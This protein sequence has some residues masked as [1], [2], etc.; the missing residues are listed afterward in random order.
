MPS[1]CKAICLGLC[2]VFA[3]CF[4]APN[5][6]ADSFTPTFIP[7][8]C[9][10]ACLPAPTAPD[11]SFPSPTTMTVT[12]NGFVFLFPV[13]APASPTDHFDWTMDWHNTDVTCLSSC[14]GEVIAS[15]AGSAPF[16]ESVTLPNVA[17]PGPLSSV[18][19]DSGQLFFAPVV[20]TPEPSSLA[21]MLA[22]IGL[23]L[24]V[25]RKR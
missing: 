25:M 14:V 11:V 15:L 19:R 18:I 5:A 24:V 3:L 2:L 21:L 6:H 4:V 16:S 13:P 1:I 22:A 12:W 17:S 8:S 20:G 10:G 9:Q 7:L 23:G